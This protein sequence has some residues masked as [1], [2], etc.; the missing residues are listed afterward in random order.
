M[1]KILAN[2]VQRPDKLLQE[3]G[4]D[5]FVDADIGRGASV[6]IEICAE[7]H[8]PEYDILAVIIIGFFDDTTMV[9]AMQARR[10]KYP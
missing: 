3:A 4:R 1:C 6:R 9:P 5:I 8:V 10:V 2:L 7:Q